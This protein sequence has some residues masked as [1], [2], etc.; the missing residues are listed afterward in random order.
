MTLHK[1]KIAETSIHEITFLARLRKKCQKFLLVRLIRKALAKHGS[2][3]VYYNS[4]QVSLL[5]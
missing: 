2:N 3:T 1:N 5:E 4:T